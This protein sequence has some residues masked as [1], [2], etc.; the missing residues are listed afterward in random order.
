VRVF[1]S[2]AVDSAGNIA[3]ATLHPEEGLVVMIQPEGGIVRVFRL[4]QP[5]PFVTNICFGGPAIC[6]AYVTCGSLGCIYAFEWPVPGLD[7]NFNKL[8]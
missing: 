4:P 8:T 1:D 6:T 3:G 5:E 2:I 7:L